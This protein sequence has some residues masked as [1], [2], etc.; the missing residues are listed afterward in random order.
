M[1]KNKALVSLVFGLGIILIGGFGLLIFG[2]YQRASDPD[3]KFFSENSDKPA[4]ISPAANPTPRLN[5][6][7]PV[8][9]SIP[10]P[11]GERIKEIEASGNR[12]IVH[13]TN[14]A[15]QDQIMVLDAETGAVIRRLRFD[16]QP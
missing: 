1:H 11:K 4:Q 10:L 15:K 9:I 3:F 13:I 7:L 8:N 2:L 16:P 14:Q 6:N 5:T 12:I